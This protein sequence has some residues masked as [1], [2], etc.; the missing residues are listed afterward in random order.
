[1]NILV[2]SFADI[3]YDG[4]LRELIRIAE[5]LGTVTFLGKKELIG[6]ESKGF[7]RLSLQYLNAICRSKIFFRK[8]GP[9]DIIL[10]DNRRALLPAYRL[11][12]M[13]SDIFLV[14]DARELYLINDVKGLIAKLGC[15][16][17]Q[18]ILPKSDVV[19][20]ANSFR[21]KFMEEYY[22]LKRPVLVFEN[23]R[24]LS[25]GDRHPEEFEN[26]KLANNLNT[27]RI[28]IVS[29]SGC[30]ISRGN[31]R[32]VHAM[33]LFE[34]EVH[35]FL[36]GRSPESDV[37]HIKEIIEINRI[38]NVTIIDQVDEATLKFILTHCHIGVVNYHQNDLNNRYC[39]SGK[40]YEFLFD[41]LPVLTT[42]NPP[43][44]ELVET[45]SIGVADDAFIYGLRELI[46]NYDYFKRNVISYAKTVS[47]DDNNNILA[48][49]ILDRKSGD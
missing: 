15:L 21:A 5:L 22:K 18:F 47:I 42:E 46:E 38:S 30:I 36:V 20:A 19:I 33:K 40:I 48:K 44:Q 4:R 13:S 43:L 8:Y 32:L 34:N 45:Y 49:A 28:N 9:F 31:D 41:G 17:E 14:S 25:F 2:I 39:A 27:G 35:L 16:I 23:L 7:A 26:T 1:M 11:K 29:T 12:R 10:A 3:A 6:D 37:S 24:K